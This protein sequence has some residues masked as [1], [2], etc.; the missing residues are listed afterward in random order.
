MQLLTTGTK[1]MIQS[2]S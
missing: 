1:F 2:P